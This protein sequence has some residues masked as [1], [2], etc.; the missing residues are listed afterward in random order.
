MNNSEFY[1]ILSVN[2]LIESFLN[3]GINLSELSELI[4]N[5]D[6]LKYFPPIIYDL[7]FAYEL[8]NSRNEI[9]SNILNSD[10][11][12][13]LKIGKKIFKL[14]RL[15]S[16]HEIVKNSEKIFQLTLDIKSEP[17]SKTKRKKL[18]KKREEPEEEEPEEEISTSGEEEPEEPEE[19]ISTSGEDE[20]E[21]L[22]AE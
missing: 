8:A 12:T 6:K 16:D 4:F 5:N 22:E 7:K 3:Y 11:D 10:Y 1:S 18:K 2:Q 13:M 14:E 19:E 20:S 9:E 21:E 17:L 15:K